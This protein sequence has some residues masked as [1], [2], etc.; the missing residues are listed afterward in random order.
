MSL[1]PP[2]KVGKLQAALHDKAKRSPS[3]RF[4]ALYDKVWREDVLRHACDRCRENDGSP[5]GWT[6]KASNKSNEK[7]WKHGW[8]N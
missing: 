5:L 2:I 7:A 4:Y 6:G 1:A 3:Y 8:V